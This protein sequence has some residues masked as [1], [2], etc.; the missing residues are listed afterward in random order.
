MP[1]KS[2]AADPTRRARPYL[3]GLA[4]LGVMHHPLL[5]H[6]ARPIPLFQSQFLPFSP[7]RTTYTREN[8]VKV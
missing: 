3:G 4:R 5:T 8:A 1:R 2:T 7:R 6:Q